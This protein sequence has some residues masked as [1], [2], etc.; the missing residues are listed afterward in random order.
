MFGKPNVYA[1]Y[2]NQRIC[3]QSVRLNTIQRTIK[4]TYVTKYQKG[5]K[6]IAASALNEHP[7]RVSKQC[8]LFGIQ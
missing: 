6:Y 8:T 2:C 5:H 1:N 7:I 4:I 3:K